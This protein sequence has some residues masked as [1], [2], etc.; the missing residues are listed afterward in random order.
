LGACGKTNVETDFVVALS[1]IRFDAVFTANPNENPLCGLKIILSFRGKTATATVVDRCEGCAVNDVDM[2][3]G[4][5]KRFQRPEV[6]RFY[7]L[8]WS[9]A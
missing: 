6:G 5:F 2:T 3:L 1:M 8:T 4:L 9:Y 7:N